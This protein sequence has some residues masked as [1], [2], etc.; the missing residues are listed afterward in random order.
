[1]QIIYCATD[2]TEAHLVAGMLQN[3][4][5]DASVQ[6]HFLQGGVGELGTMDF[7]RVMVPDDETERALPIIRAYEQ[8]AE[9]PRLSHR[10]GVRLDSS[11]W[12]ALALAVLI[13]L[14]LS[15]L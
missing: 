11:L 5:V 12:L 15:V 3:E 8:A 13:A 14:L 6:G 10:Q 1:M 4:G 9:T 7:A 2:I